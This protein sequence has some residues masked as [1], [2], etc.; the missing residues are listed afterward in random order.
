M[1]IIFQYL[2]PSVYLF[3][4][5]SRGHMYSK[6]DIMLEYKNTQNGWFFK[7]RHV[8]HHV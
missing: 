4:K 5:L 3:A 1:S 6:V 7:E 2:G 8:P